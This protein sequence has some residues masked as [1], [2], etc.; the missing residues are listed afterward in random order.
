M[1]FTTQRK[2]IR[3]MQLETGMS[4]KFCTG[5]ISRL[6]KKKDG[7]RY[8]LNT[9]TLRESIDEINGLKAPV[10]KKPSILSKRVRQRIRSGALA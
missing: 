1:S 3:Q 4:K 9:V 7:A 5:I 8:K 10:L 6:P 2:A